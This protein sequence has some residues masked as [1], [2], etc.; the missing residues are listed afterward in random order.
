MKTI[1]EC[2]DLWLA[3]YIGFE[4]WPHLLLVSFKNYIC[5]SVSQRS[6]SFIFLPWQKIVQAFE[7]FLKHE[8][9]IRRQYDFIFKT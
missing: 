6:C 5:P 2:A 8:K 7:E 9:N 4:F 1:M 3:T